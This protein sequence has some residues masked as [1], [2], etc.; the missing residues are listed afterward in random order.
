MEVWRPSYK[1][2]LIT[3]EFGVTD[4]EDLCFKYNYCQPCVGYCIVPLNVWCRKF[5]KFASYFVLRSHDTSHKNNFG[6]I[7]SF[8][9]YGNTVFEAVSKLVESASDFIAWRAEALNKYG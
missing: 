8:T 2:S 5:G 7:T 4:L 3:R 9:S 6:V 1:Y